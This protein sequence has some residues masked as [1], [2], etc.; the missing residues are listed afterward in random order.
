[1]AKIAGYRMCFAVLR[2]DIPS[3]PLS[4]HL[5]LCAGKSPGIGGFLPSKNHINKNQMQKECSTQ[6]T[7]D[8]IMDFRRC[9]RRGAT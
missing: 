9:L 4:A 5:N 8:M 3:S 2:N 7:N 1:M 6:P